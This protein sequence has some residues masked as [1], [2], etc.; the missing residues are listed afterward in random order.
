MRFD[1]VNFT[2]IDNED[3]VGKWGGEE[4]VIKAGETKPFP[5]FLVEHFTK[6]LV[7]KILIRDKVENYQDPVLREPLE[8]QIKGEIV[9]EKQE[10]KIESEGERVKKEVEKSQKEFEELEELK[11]QQLR[12]KRIEALKKA[13][14]IKAQKQKKE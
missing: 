9:F 8:R 10:E 5:A 7:N 11:K 13:R 2:N 1:L 4:Y 14:A 6:H 12:E 3:F